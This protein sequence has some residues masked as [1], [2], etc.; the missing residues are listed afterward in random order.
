MKMTLPDGETGVFATS[1]MDT[2]K[3]PLDELA[4]LYCSRWRIETAFREMKMWHTFEH[5]HAEHARGIYQG[6]TVLMIFMLL[7][8][9][10]EMMTYEYYE[11]EIREI[12]E[13]TPVEEKKSHC[14]EPH[15]RWNRKVIAEHIV[16]IMRAGLLGQGQS[17]EISKGGGQMCDVSLTALGEAPPRHVASREGLKPRRR[18]EKAILLFF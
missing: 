18:K 14:A 1:L 13:A 16:C 8:A 7:T 12:E 10:L 15:I 3:F 17:A 9:E 2:E 4:S 11:D 6:I 5:M